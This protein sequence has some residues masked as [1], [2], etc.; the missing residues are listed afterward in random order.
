MEGPRWC[1]LQRVAEAEPGAA[2]VGAGDVGE[3]QV[4][5]RRGSK[6]KAGS[7]HK[8]EQEHG[9]GGDAESTFGA[10]DGIRHWCSPKRN[11]QARPAA[12]QPRAAGARARVRRGERGLSSSKDKDIK[13]CKDCKDQKKPRSRV[14]RVFFVRS[15]CQSVLVPDCPCCP[16]THSSS[17][18]L[19]R[20]ARR[21][22]GGTFS[23]ARA[24][25]ASPLAHEEARA[26]A[27]A[28][29]ISRRAIVG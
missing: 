28:R 1:D 24:R 2:V 6:R 7:R 17:T 26:A 10:H 11:R 13:D 5:P 19:P 14:V 29:P 15:P 4:L 27:T 8:G 22:S 21:S 20:T 9:R 16:C 12:A 23:S 3:R 18:R 25:S